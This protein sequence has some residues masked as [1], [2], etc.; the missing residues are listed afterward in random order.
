MVKFASIMVALILGA[1]GFGGFFHHTANVSTGTD[2]NTAVST[3]T[4]AGVQTASSSDVAK[5]D[6][7]AVAA[8]PSDTAKVAV[9]VQ[10]ADATM[11]QLKV[12][13]VQQ[14]QSLDPATATTLTDQELKLV[15]R[16]EVQAALLSE[17]ADRLRARADVQTNADVK[18]ALEAAA[19]KLDAI[20]AFKTTLSTKLAAD[21]IQPADVKAQLKAFEDEHGFSAGWFGQW[22]GAFHH[23]DKVSASG[24]TKVND[25]KGVTSASFKAQFKNDGD[26]NDHDNGHG[27]HFGRR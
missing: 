23:K 26:D 25:N 13:Q 17:V 15:T 3:Q 14:A 2:T 27:H 12:L 4:A 16:L 19:A 7:Q 8:A 21:E 1:V 5:A 9:A 18:A 22:F 20:A 11:A 10:A 24:T 6:I